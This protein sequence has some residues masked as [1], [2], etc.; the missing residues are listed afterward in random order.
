MTF[1]PDPSCT[2]RETE[3]VCYRTDC[4]LAC[5]RNY[6]DQMDCDIP[7]RW[8]SPG[9]RRPARSWWQEHVRRLA[10]RHVN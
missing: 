10:S 1:K 4:P 5:M 8:N 2:Y 6:R 9:V 3:G 7:I